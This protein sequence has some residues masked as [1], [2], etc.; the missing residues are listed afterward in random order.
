MATLQ[1]AQAAAAATVAELGKRIIRAD[2]ELAELDTLVN[3][4]GT[5][6]TLQ[7]Q[8]AERVADHTAFAATTGTVGESELAR[9]EKVAADAAV[10]ARTGASTTDGGAL[11]EARLTTQ[12]AWTAAETA[13]TTAKGALDTVLSGA[14]LVAL[15]AT[16]AS[17]TAAWNTQ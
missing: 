16:V 3:A 4:S 12:A 11:T 10:K 14:D 5:A 17:D 1:A 15:R 8:Q 2:T 13:V 9:L 6:G 7:Q